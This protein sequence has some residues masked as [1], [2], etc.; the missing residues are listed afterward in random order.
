MQVSVDFL[1][2]AADL[3]GSVS[4]TNTKHDMYKVKRN[5]KNPMNIHFL[6]APDMVMLIQTIGMLAQ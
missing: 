6:E 3:K 1:K 5:L 4:L 2:I